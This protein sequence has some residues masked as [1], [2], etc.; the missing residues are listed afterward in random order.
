MNLLDMQHVTLLSDIL[1]LDAF[2]IHIHSEVTHTHIFYS[3]PA[4]FTPQ[5]WMPTILTHILMTQKDKEV[6]TT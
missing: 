6:T 3:D 5:A 2:D 4:H 1:N